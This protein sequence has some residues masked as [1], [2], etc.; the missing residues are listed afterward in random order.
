[1]RQAR[2]K[3][4]SVVSHGGKE[5]SATHFCLGCLTRENRAD[6]MFKGSSLSITRGLME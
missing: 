2:H 1:M 3:V 5:T 4:V 6:A